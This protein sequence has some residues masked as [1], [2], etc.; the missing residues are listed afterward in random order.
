MFID[1]I[2]RK[3]VEHVNRSH[4]LRVTFGQVIV[5]GHHMHSSV[6]KSIKEYR[7]GG[8]QCFSFT[9]CH[10]GNLTL[11]KHHAPKQ[12]HI[13]MDHVPGYFIAS[14]NPAIQVDSLISLYT[15]KIMPGR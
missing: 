9:G 10:F 2:Y 14:S 13:V 1:T 7:Q 8:H 12:L 5:H 6:C 3:P 4:P 15:H 11:M